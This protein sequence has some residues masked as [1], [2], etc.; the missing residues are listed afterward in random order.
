MHDF[1]VYDIL[2]DGGQVFEELKHSYGILS[3]HDASVDQ[4]HTSIVEVGRIW[5]HISIHLR[6]DLGEAKEECLI[7]CVRSCRG[8]IWALSKSL[9]SMRQEIYGSSPRLILRRDHAR[10]PS[11]L[12]R[13]QPVVKTTDSDSTYGVAQR[14]KAAG[15]RASCGH[16]LLKL[17]LAAGCLTV[18]IHYSAAKDVTQDGFTAA[19]EIRAA[20]TPAPV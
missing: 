3:E 19:G 15:V 20:A 8:D 6:T 4:I 18:S 10:I 1:A 17:I 5:D 2:A 13:L 11:V 12:S 7:S 9:E 16:N 14:R